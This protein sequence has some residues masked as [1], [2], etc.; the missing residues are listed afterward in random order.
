[1]RGVSEVIAIILILM[2]TISLAGLSYIFMSTTM[3]DVT[4]S[5][6]STVDT[7]TS[8]MLT[9]FTI[10][11]MDV[12]KVYIRN[13]GQNAL[14]SLSIYVDSEP[15]AFNV[16]TPITPGSIGT[17]TIYSFIPDG[18]AVKVVSPSGFSASKVARPCEKA[19]GCW[20]FDEG[21]G[22][23]AYDSSQY[24]N[25]GTLSGPI[26][27]S[28]KYGSA[29]RFD[30]VNDYVLMGSTSLLAPT[31][32]LTACALAR[33]ESLSAQQ[34][35]ISRGRDNYGSGYNLY[36]NPSR[37]FSEINLDDVN[38][39]QEIDIWSAQ[40]STGTWYYS[41]MSYNSATGAK[42]YVNG[43]EEASSAVTGQI[44]FRPG[45]GDNFV[46]GTMSYSYPAYF[47]FNGTIDE[48]RIYSRNIY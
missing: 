33:F 10:E 11:S 19:V 48:V 24:G 16:T 47:P 46:I 29:L 28:G 35:L 8:S 43:V 7:T 32:T 6:G 41:C 1:M 15:A 18:A 31:Q 13:T 2:I 12:A 22:T 36:M 38:D 27:T 26:W 17:I 21:S 9:S 25:S 3:G 14:T 42:L 30:G 37:F 34:Y 39:D 44:V 45:Q 23:T 20:K 5:A 40:I 4:S